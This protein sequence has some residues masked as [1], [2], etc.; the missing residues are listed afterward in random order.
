[1]NVKDFLIGA[2]TAIVGAGI[3]V[4]LCCTLCCKKCD[5][6]CDKPMPP[7]PTEQ[8]GPHHDFDGHKHFGK[9]AMQMADELNLSEEQKAQIKT[10]AD[11]QKEELKQIHK[12]FDE[13]FQS[14]LTDEQKAKFEELKAQKKCPKGKKCPKDKPQDEDEDED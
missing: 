1:M 4:V 11:T 3:G 10:F 13:S 7:C 8:R 6:P 14:I 12:K 5:K 2:C 9:C